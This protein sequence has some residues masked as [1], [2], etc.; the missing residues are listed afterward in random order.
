MSSD[1]SHDG[2]SQHAGRSLNVIRSVVRALNLNTR[3]IEQQSGISLA[4]LFVLEQLAQHPAS[5][6]TDLAERT[7]THQSSVSVVVQRLVDR[8]FVNRTRS[9]SDR[10]FVEIVIT[11]AGRDVLASAPETVQVKLLNGLHRFEDGE[12]ERLAALLE[13]WAASA[14]IEVPAETPMFLED[15]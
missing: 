7:A 15:A 13:R 6:L 5:S 3:A 11:D 14:G 4:Q 9:A 2:H 12:R 10:R 1:L 8:G